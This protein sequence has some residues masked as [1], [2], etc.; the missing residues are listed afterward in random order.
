MCE[1]ADMAV[2]GENEL[3]AR[4]MAVKPDGLSLHAW[5]QRA[6]VSRTF[7]NDVRKRGNAR[8]DSLEKLLAAAGVTFAEFE[9]QP[10]EHRATVRSEVK[11]TGMSPEQVRAAWAMP[12]PSRPVPLLG[13]AFGSELAD[14]EDVETTELMLSE[15]L[16]YIAR[17]PSLAN[18][19]DAYAVTVI[20]DSMAPRFEPSEVVFVSPRSPVNVNDDVLV[21]IRSASDEGEDNQLAGRVSTVLLKRLVRRSGKSIELL[22]FNPARTFT[23][24]IERVRRIHRVRGRL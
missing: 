17:P 14:V 13:T 2:T 23:V 6:G 5:T 8:H 4:L 21:Q 18:D 12:E 19:D 10:A 3:Y 9:G 16:D 24:P 15:V 22:Q 20:G 11:A 1:I 7:F